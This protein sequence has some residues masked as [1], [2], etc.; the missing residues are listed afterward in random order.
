MRFTFPWRSRRSRRDSLKSG[1]RSPSSPRMESLEARLLLSATIE[2]FVTNA[3]TGLPVVGVNVDAG[4]R[5]GPNNENWTYIASGVTGT[6]GDYLITGLPGGSYSLQVADGVV[7]AGVHY[8][9]AHLDNVAVPTDA[10]V[11]GQDFD[12]HQ[13]GLIYGYVKDAAGQPIQEAQVLVEASYTQYGD[14]W[15]I[16]STDAT[17]LYQAWVPV[18]AAAIYPVRA[19]YAYNPGATYHLFGTT[20]DLGSV[21]PDDFTGDAGAAGCWGSCRGVAERGGGG[22]WWY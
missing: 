6:S 18:S 3:T 5:S 7:S 14:D 4:I 8:T 10:F 20:S 21:P 19:L 13:A 16:F 11:S 9:G 22:A 15:H 12:L 17:G 2:G 1:S